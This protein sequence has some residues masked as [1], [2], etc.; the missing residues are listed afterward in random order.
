[1]TV[2]K[3]IEREIVV[4][5]D[6]AVTFMGEGLRVYGT[7]FMIADIEMACRDLVL[8]DLAEGE[9]TVGAHLL[10]DHLGPAVFGNVV[11][12]LAEVTEHSGRLIEFQA[13]V[14]RKDSL[15]GTAFHRRAVVDLK[16]LKGKL[17]ALRD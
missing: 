3:T 5:G 4:D 16:R 9:D 14:F 10:V 12:I 15:V 7:P 2:G 17:A 13:K 1:M 8:P 6:R 11:R